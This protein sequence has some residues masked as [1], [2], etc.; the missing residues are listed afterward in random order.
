MSKTQK[1]SSLKLFTTAHDFS[2]H[3]TWIQLEC[4]WL[5]CNSKTNVFR[6]ACLDESD[7]RRL[8]CHTLYSYNALNNC[9]Y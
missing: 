6:V 8:K 1:Q 9:C 2:V 4:A 5:V 3:D 7:K